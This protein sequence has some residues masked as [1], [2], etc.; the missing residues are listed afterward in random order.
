MA[1][2]ETGDTT[3]E[4]WLSLDEQDADWP[5]GGRTR[6]T[7]PLLTVVIPTYNEAHRVQQTLER[8]TAYLATRAYRWELLIADDG[9]TDHTVFI[10]HAVAEQWPQMRILTAERNRGK[11]AAIRRGMLAARGV[12]TLFSDADLSTP[13]EEIER[14]LPHLRNG[15]DV[16]IG[17]RA[18]P[19][20]RI[21]TRQP[22]Q[23][24][25]M[26]HAFHAL[27]RQL[28]LPSIRDSQCGFK[29]FRTAAARHIFSQLTVERFACDV[30]VLL[31]AEALGYHTKELG[32]T[33]ADVPGTRVSP[34]RDAPRMFRD[35][36][37]L[38]KGV[39][40]RLDDA[41]DTVPGEQGSVLALITLRQ[42]NG[43]DDLPIDSAVNR[44]WRAQ[45][46]VVMGAWPGA[47]LLATFALT[48]GE[49]AVVARRLAD[50]S[51]NALAANGQSSAVTVDVQLLPLATPVTWL[52]A[53]AGDASP[54]AEGSPRIKEPSLLDALSAIEQRRQAEQVSVERRQ[55]EWK[56]RRRAVRLLIA[57]NVIG[58]A[59]WLLWLFNPANAANALLYTLLVLAEC[60]NIV[61]VLGYW[62]TV[63]HE[64]APER[65]QA[66]VPGNVDIF[67]TTYNEPVA[68]VEQTV[69]AAVAMPY[70][71]RTYVLDDGHRPA[72]GQMAARHGAYWLTRPNNRGAK[73]GNINHALAATDG[74]FF[75]VFDADH[76]PHPDFLT[77]LMP[78]LADERVAFVQA[79]QYYVNRHSTYIAGAAMDQQELFFGPICK[80]KDG[81]GAVFCCGT[82][83]VIR[84]AA[85][86]AV[87]GFR[88]DSITED[89]A[90]SLDLHEHGWTSRYVGE[91]LADGL[92][93]E[94]LG[95]YVSQQ[96][97]WAR[98]NIDMLFRANVFGRRMPWR[99]RFQYA[100][101]AMY[102]LTS[103]TTVLYL[104]LPCL[105]L[106]FGV[107][108][109]SAQ[110]TD[111]IGHFL[112]YIFTTIFILARSAEGRLRFRAIQVSYGLFPVFIGALY[113]VVSGRKVGF[114]VTP[115]EGRVQSFYGLVVP[116]LS[117]V[118]VSVLAILVGFAHYAGPSTI[119]NACWALF[120]AILLSGI[121]RAAAPQRTRQRAPHRPPLREEVFDDV[122]SVS[123]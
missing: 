98:G 60:F 109:V 49:V 57:A 54:M 29:V 17:S 10:A 73:A 48:S 62:Y 91:R 104:A 72:M 93:P 105:Y 84:R 95:A 108:T 5:M 51:A 35:V 6:E 117:A 69:R 50:A 39:R 122:E 28:A 114:T 76:V 79:P 3:P 31:L 38:R 20:S 102:Y 64:R 71:H 120:N 47:A 16:V 80:G 9:S 34:L 33:W 111:F 45:D 118:G 2:D 88:E 26:G 96:R 52:R 43:R 59:W 56:R 83:M 106:L 40:A 112:P 107:Q 24:W 25:V 13:I 110:S 87:G 7:N 81:L 101:S 42:V 8:V 14:F 55:A 19:D 78:H 123:A 4:T 23:R 22:V 70:P 66:R 89:A 58:L 119:T 103:L 77:R 53:P 75:V 12:Y 44:V 36:Y 94:D 113:S 46:T 86:A 68:L 21:I 92:A 100:W 27:T 37:G 85:I 32:V 82:N 15:C 90:T 65:P 61:Q 41:L 99:L 121:I 63:W 116:Q 74:D 18:M 67:I 115:K 1:F 97:R 11:G 30:E